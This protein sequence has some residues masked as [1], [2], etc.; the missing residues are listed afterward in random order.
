MNLQLKKPK[1]VITFPGQLLM[2][3]LLIQSKRWIC[4]ASIVRR[5]FQVCCHDQVWVRYYQNSC[6]LSKQGPITCHCLWSATVCI[7]KIG[8]IELE[9]ELLRKVLC[10]HDRSTAHWNGSSKNHWRV[11][12]RLKME[13]SFIWSRYCILRDCRF[14]PSH[15]SCYKIQ[16]GASGKYKY[17]FKKLNIFWD[18]K[19]DNVSAIAFI[20][21]HWGFI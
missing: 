13:L 15:C 5:M 17:F 2:H 7:S 12:G 6:W 18:S 9:R 8:A 16:K 11:V 20:D 19:H 14:F 4:F 1:E 3:H 21:F 10:L